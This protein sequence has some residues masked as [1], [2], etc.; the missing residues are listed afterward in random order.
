[1]SKKKPYTEPAIIGEY[2]YDPALTEHITELEAI[3]REIGAVEQLVIRSVD[4]VWLYYEAG[5]EVAEKRLSKSGLLFICRFTASD[6]PVQ[7]QT[8]G[9]QAGLKHPNQQTATLSR[10]PAKAAN[11]QKT[12]AVPIAGELTS[13]T[14]PEDFQQFVAITHQLHNDRAITP[15]DDNSI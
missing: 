13:Q 3:C 2:P 7:R 14:T 8:G 10:S 4:N 5:G 1:M 6:L 15:P 12:I 11:N 9:A